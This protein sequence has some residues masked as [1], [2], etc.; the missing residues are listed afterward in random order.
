ML[1]LWELLFKRRSLIT[2]EPLLRL[3]LYFWVKKNLS[4]K[5]QT[6][7]SVLIH[8]SLTNVKNQTC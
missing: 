8:L 3:P 1:F 6:K 5:T 4:H 7:G 2:V